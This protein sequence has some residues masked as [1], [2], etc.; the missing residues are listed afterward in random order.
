MK[1]TVLYITW[2]DTSVKEVWWHLGCQGLSKTKVWRFYLL[3]LAVCAPKWW[4][5]IVAGGGRRIGWKNYP[6]SVLP[7]HLIRAIY[8]SPKMITWPFLMHLKSDH[9]C[10]FRTEWGTFLQSSRKKWW[11]LEPGVAD[12]VP[13]EPAARSVMVEECSF[14]WGFHRHALIPLI[15]CRVAHWLSKPFTSLERRTVLV[16]PRPKSHFW[17][18]QF[19]G[20]RA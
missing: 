16:L 2:E 13:R 7:V 15:L 6:C 10:C 8:P 17:L 18:L 11:S 4:S 20:N 3:A 9:L 12:P 19:Q 1:C 5:E 14:G